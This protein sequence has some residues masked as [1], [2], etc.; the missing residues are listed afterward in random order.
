MASITVSPT[1]LQAP[2][3]GIFLPTIAGWNTISGL[4]SFTLV[5]RAHRNV[6]PWKTE[7]GNVA[8]AVGRERHRKEERGARAG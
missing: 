3:Q 1:L 2:S 7:S 6:R 8:T 5:C 4:C